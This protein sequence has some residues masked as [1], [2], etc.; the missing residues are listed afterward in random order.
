MTK[1]KAAGR[2]SRSRNF[3]GKP[4]ARGSRT[5]VDHTKAT[6][7]YVDPGSGRIGFE[8]QA[9]WWFSTRVS[10]R[11]PTRERDRGYLERYVLPTFGG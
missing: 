7:R 5:L 3:S 8:A 2:D 10:L 6:G 9:W 11:E 4:D 1:E